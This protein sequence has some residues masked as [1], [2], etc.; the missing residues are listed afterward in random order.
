M[1]FK[2]FSKKDFVIDISAPKNTPNLSQRIWMGSGEPPHGAYLKCDKAGYW[3]RNYPSPFIFHYC[4]LVQTLDKQGTGELIIPLCLH[5][6]GQSLPSPPKFLLHRKV[7]RIFWGWSKNHAAQGPLLLETFEDPRVTVQVAGKSV[8]FNRFRSCLVCTSC[9]S[10]E[11]LRSQ[12]S[13][14]VDE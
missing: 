11:I 13:D 5:K 10:G 12:I 3:V 2:F 6:G 9:F 4:D 8:I 1:A 7:H 14:G